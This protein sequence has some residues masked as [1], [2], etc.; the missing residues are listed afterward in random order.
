LATTGEAA[1]ELQGAATSARSDLMAV[2]VDLAHENAG[3]GAVEILRLPDLHPV[4]LLK[5]STGVGGG[6]GFSPDGS[7]LAVGGQGSTT[8]YDTRSWRPLG[9]ALVGHEGAAI[10]RVVFS[11]DGQTLATGGGDGTVRLWDVAT[12][13]AIGAGIPVDA[14]TGHLGVAFVLGGA[15]LITLSYGEAFAWDLRPEAWM[16]AACAIAGRELTRGEWADVLPGRG[17]DPACG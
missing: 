14:G 3:A 7:L 1:G 8:L 17:Y 9:H 15:R 6:L 12:Q 4:K 11:P 13:S 5:A 16:H 2:S 10:D